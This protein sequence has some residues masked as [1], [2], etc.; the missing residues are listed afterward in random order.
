MKSSRRGSRSRRIGA[1]LGA[2]ALLLVASGGTAGAEG[3]TPQLGGFS[4]LAVASGQ[5]STFT[6]TKFLVIQ[7]FF[8]GTG[9]VA[10]STLDPQSGGES[11][12]SFPYPGA[13]VL[14]YPAFVTLGTGQT[15]PG[16]PLYVKATPTENSKALS[17]PTDS[18]HLEAKAGQQSAESTGRLRAASGDALRAG[19]MSTTSILTD[20]QKVVASAESVTEGLSI[21]PLKIGS[22]TSKSVTT[23]A[24]GDDSPKTTTEMHLDGGAVNDQRFSFG[25]GGLTLTQGGVPVPVSQS[26]ETLN[27]ALKPAGISVRFLEPQK[28]AGGG[29]S[30]T[31]E[32]SALREVPGGGSGVLRLQFGQA[33]SAVVPGG[34]YLSSQPAAGNPAESGPAPDTASAPGD[35][36]NPSVPATGASP[37]VAESQASASAF[38]SAPTVDLAGDV[39]VPGGSALSGPSGADLGDMASGQSGGGELA[40]PAAGAGLAAAPGPGGTAGAVGRLASAAD[41]RAVDGVY[42]A[43]AWATI[44]VLV[45]SLIWRQGARKWTS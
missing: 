5:R 45:L 20:G 32:V 3:D 44:A 18:Y 31:F 21:G 8:D 7:E 4:A 16:Y 42:A 35:A 30:G 6:V 33:T 1:L 41:P 2:G 43:V 12:A 9:P 24:A 29:Q 40:A 17:D 25:P 14:Q 34:D 10:E 27:A 38:G 39:S 13:T 26:V 23:L 11:F 19:T 22:I 37:A 36:A 15:P 28:I